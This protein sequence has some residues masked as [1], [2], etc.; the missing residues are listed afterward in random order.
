VTAL[1]E[2]LEARGIFPYRGRG[3]HFLINKNIAKRIVE[4]ALVTGDDIVVEI[5][6]GTGS[7][8]GLLSERAKKVI[9]IESDKK[10]CSLIEEE[11]GGDTVE[12]ILGDA[13]K[14]DFSALGE[15]LGSR[16]TVVANLPYNISTEMIFVLLDARMQIERIVL[17]LQREV[18]KRLTARPGTKEYGGLTVFASLFADIVLNFSVGRKNFYPP[19][20]VDSVVVTFDIRQEPRVALS[21]Y[22]LFRRVVRAAFGNRR[23]TLRN[24]LASLPDV[25]TKDDLGRIA[26]RYGI[27]LGRRGE[28]L[29][30]S[31][32]A[33]LTEAV[34]MVRSD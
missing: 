30:L 23:K 16:Y 31:E 3:Q 2:T 1:R 17:M 28:T 11:F 14:F 34:R 15:R 32:F 4:T 25:T 6:P 33:L 27:D 22:A 18:G 29:T 5:G 10:L 12:V 13:L 19:P 7:L 20:R 24:C 21:D 8:T 26:E 9:A